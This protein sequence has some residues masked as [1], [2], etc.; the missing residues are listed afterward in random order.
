MLVGVVAVEGS[1]DGEGERAILLALALALAA[2]VLYADGAVDGDGDTRFRFELDGFFAGPRAGPREAAESAFGGTVGRGAETVAWEEDD[3][4][5]SERVRVVDRWRAGP[6][7]EG[8]T[9]C[10]VAKGCALW[11][12]MDVRLTSASRKDWPMSRKSSRGSAL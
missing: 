9:A 12:E 10:A 1:V 5:L 4:L 7:D 3:W 2:G 8:A 11:E 6:N